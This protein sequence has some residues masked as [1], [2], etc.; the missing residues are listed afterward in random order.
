MQYLPSR[1]I[2][3]LMVG[4]L[5][6][7]GFWFT[8]RDRNTAAKENAGN[9]ISAESL[10]VQDQSGHQDS[11]NDGLEDWEEQLFGTDPHNPDSD[12]NGLLDGEEF[13]SVKKIAEIEPTDNVLNYLNQVRQA[14]A[15]QGQGSIIPEAV[16]EIPPDHYRAVDLTIVATNDV[17]VTR[18]VVGVLLATKPYEENPDEEDPMDTISRWLE[19]NDPKELEAL[20]AQSRKDKLLAAELVALSVPDELAALHLEFVNSVYSGARSLEEIE[21]T[22]H[23]PQMEFFAVAKYANYRG[24]RSKTIIELTQYFNTY[25]LTLNEE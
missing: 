8:L 1:K 20:V 12:G 25:T 11:D 2:M 3:F 18:Y 7:G 23:N 9:T 22:T 21:L 13:A 6:V 10:L 4:I 24:K 17:S 14:L 15:N 16:L 19:S 5:V